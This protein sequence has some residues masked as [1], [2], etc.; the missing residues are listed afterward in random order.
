M[1]L[2]CT[3]KDWDKNMKEII[4]IFTFAHVHSVYYSG[5]EFDYCPWCGKELIKKEGI[6]YD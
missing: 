5:E 3:C 2:E 4:G 1:I 6:K